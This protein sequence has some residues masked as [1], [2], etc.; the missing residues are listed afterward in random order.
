MRHNLGHSNAG[1]YI[2]SPIN[3]W[4]IWFENLFRCRKVHIAIHAY[5][6]NFVKLVWWQLFPLWK[7]IY[8][9]QTWK[10]AWH[11]YHFFKIWSK[12]Y[13]PSTLSKQWR[14]LQASPMDWPCSKIFKLWVISFTFQVFWVKIHFK[15]NW[16]F[17]IEILIV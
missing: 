4:L 14:Y 3:H 13:I 11:L 15:L 5:N 1:F 17:R 10:V 6:I 7:M 12:F 8:F 2:I 9:E 16:K